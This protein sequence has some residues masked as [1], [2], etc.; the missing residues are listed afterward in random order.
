MKRSLLMALSVGIAVSLFAG[1][2]SQQQDGKK[3]PS[4]Q[5]RLIVQANPGGGS[6]VNCRTIAPGVEKA[7]GVPVVVENMPGGGGGVAITWGA[8]QPADGYIIN[9]LP[10]DVAI[11]KPSGMA[12]VTPDDFDFICRVNY[13]GASIAVKADSKYKTV[14]DLINDAKSRPGQ[15]TVGNSGV[16]TLWNLAAVQLE[17][18]TG[19]QFS[20]IPFEGAGPGITALMGG[21]LD[22]MICGPNEAGPQVQGGDLRLLALFY[23]NRMSLFPDVPTLKELGIDIVVL[24]YMGFGVPKG[25]PPDIVAVLEKAFK[26]S[27]DSQVYQDM[28]KARGLEPGWMGGKEF[29][30]YVKS[31]FDKYT[32]LVPKVMGK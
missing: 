19:V 2:S 3:Y 26:E 10:V 31:D 16:G 12:D 21:H 15:V 20:H 1:G 5:I 9:H 18:Q 28:L 27:Y 29:A 7:L 4:K 24:N 30:A 23:E 14:Q 11:L 8:N 32:E 13:L 22:V 6:D 25:T 17:N